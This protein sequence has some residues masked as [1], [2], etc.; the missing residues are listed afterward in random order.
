M[1]FTTPSASP[2][3]LIKISTAFRGGNLKI[4]P[5]SPSVSYF[6]GDACE[7]QDCQEETLKP[8]PG[9][10]TPNQG[11]GPRVIL[12]RKQVFNVQRVRA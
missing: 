1:T 3:L 6:P 12:G 7:A 10:G 5:P 9:K 4:H 2:V 11:R 8:K